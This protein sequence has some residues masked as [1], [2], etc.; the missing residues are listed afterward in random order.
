MITSIVDFTSKW[1]DFTEIMVHMSLVM[2]CELMV[3]AKGL[4]IRSLFADHFT[5]PSFVVITADTIQYINLSD[6][7]IG[8]HGAVAL[9]KGE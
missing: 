2:Y 5:C 1:T 9:A 6:N 8:E 3:S 7:D 4:T